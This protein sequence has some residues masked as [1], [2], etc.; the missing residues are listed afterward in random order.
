MRKIL[1]AIFIFISSVS[2]AQ[3]DTLPAAE[4][5]EDYSQYNNVEEVPTKRYCSSKVLGIS[6]SKLISVGYDFVGSHTINAGAFDGFLENSS[7]INYNNGL[8][9]YWS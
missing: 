2:N 8:R 5:E 3:K 7:T 9:K 6:P 4:P 1:F